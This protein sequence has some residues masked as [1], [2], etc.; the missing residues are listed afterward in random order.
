MVM[1]KSTTVKDPLGN[2]LPATEVGIKETREHFNEIILDD[3][4][5]LRIKLVATKA[6][7]LQD[8]W[9]NQEIPSIS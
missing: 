5:V 3:G 1:E 4:T 6:Y 2:S 7:R 9:D 8:N